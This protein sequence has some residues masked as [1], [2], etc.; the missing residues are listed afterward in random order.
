MI[1]K[2]EPQKIITLGTNG[3]PNIKLAKQSNITLEDL[4]EKANSFTKTAKDYKIDTSER[5]IAFT[6]D[7][8]FKLREQNLSLT[9]HAFGQVCTLLG[10]PSKYMKKCIEDNKINLFQDNIKEWSKEFD[11]EIVVRTNKNIIRAIVSQNY[12]AYD[13][14]EVIDDVTSAIKDSNI[15]FIPVGAYLNEDR[16][17]VRLIDVE[18]P[19]YVNN[20]ESPM[21]IGINISNS[22]IGTSSTSIKFFVYRQWCKN[23]CTITKSGGTLYRQTHAG[24]QNKFTRRLNFYSA[25]Q[26]IE[27]LRDAVISELNKS[28]FEVLKESDMM[29][30]IEKMK[31]EVSLSDKASKTILEVAKEKYGS[32][33]YGFINGITEVAQDYELDTRNELEEYAG[34]ILIAK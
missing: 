24:E 31:K 10:V 30:L 17:N 14:N 15:S 34:K 33:K 12:V 6:D 1:L 9:E 27:H 16:I 29:S 5:K 11:K 21:Y 26:N 25:I 2:S 20:D 3:C 28:S 13:N 19:F 22:N 8:S 32:T 4:Q 7:I 23:G 18:H